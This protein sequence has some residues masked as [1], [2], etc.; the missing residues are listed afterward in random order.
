MYFTGLVLH[1][2]SEV[3][4]A[5]TK[6]KTLLSFNLTR[7][8]ANIQMKTIP[9]PYLLIPKSVKWRIFHWIRWFCIAKS[10]YS[11]TINQGMR[12]HNVTISRKM[13]RQNPILYWKRDKDIDEII[14]LARINFEL[15]FIKAVKNRRKYLLFY[16]VV[17]NN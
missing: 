3:P 8:S 7:N 9:Y 11:F 12:E 14:N 6:R 2:V 5:A 13:I 17:K 16:Y 1:L 15:A 4:K 10:M